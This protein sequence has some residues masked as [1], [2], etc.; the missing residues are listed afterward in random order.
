VQ[1]RKDCRTAVAKSESFA[2]VQKRVR[3][4]LGRSVRD[5]RLS[6]KLSQGDLAGFA[7]IRRALVS[8]I[9]RGQANATLDTLLRLA[10]ALGV[11]PAELLSPKGEIIR[12]Y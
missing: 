7:K 9:E 8:D 5:L 2:K 1:Q 3:A 11:E 4:S 6:R 12:R 10:I